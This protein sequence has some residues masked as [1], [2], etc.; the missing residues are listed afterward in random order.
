MKK[1][2]LMMLVVLA[3]LTSN[4]RTIWTGEKAVGWDDYLSRNAVIVVEW[5][6]R[7][8]SLIPANAYRISFRHCADSDETREI[9]FL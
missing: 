2:L 5:P 4:A 7:A 3:A 8:G 6:E 1:T 9:L